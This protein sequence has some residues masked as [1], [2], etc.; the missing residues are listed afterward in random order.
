MLGFTGMLAVF[1]ILNLGIVIGF[2]CCNLMKQRQLLIADKLQTWYSVTQIFV[3]LMTFIGFPI[4]QWITFWDFFRVE[5]NCKA[6]WDLLAY[7]NFIFIQL[8][9]LAPT[10][11]VTLVLLAVICC[12]PCILKEIRNARAARH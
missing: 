8:Y 2:G 3:I 11:I 1:V 6:G 7:L 4:W 5:K 9:C 12:F 10:L